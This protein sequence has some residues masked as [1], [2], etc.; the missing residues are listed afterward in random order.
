MTRQDKEDEMRLSK[1]KAAATDPKS[2]PVYREIPATAAPAPEPGQVGQA[3]VQAAT[4]NQL[5][6]YADDIEQ[7][8]NASNMRLLLNRIQG[9]LRKD[10][11]ANGP[12]M[13]IRRD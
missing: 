12:R 10:T 6:R 9:E 4:L 7:Y 5:H 11:A 1:N 2:T 3:A 13:R 8:V